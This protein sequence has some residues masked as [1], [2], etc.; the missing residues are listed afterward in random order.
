MKG[1]NIF[2]WNTSLPIGQFIWIFFIS[3]VIYII[4]LV[5]IGIITLAVSFVID[6]IYVLPIGTIIGF[7]APFYF[8]WDYIYELGHVAHSTF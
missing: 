5:A 2:T 8:L 1:G 3:I 7:I 6:P 4:V